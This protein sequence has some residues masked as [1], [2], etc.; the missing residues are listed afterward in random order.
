MPIKYYTRRNPFPFYL[1]CPCFPL[2]VSESFS[3]LLAIDCMKPIKLVK[4]MGIVLR[5]RT[6]VA[7]I[8]S[9]LCPIYCKL[10][11]LGES[12]MSFTI[13]GDVPAGHLPV[14]VGRKTTQ[15]KRFV[16]SVTDLHHP[17][18]Q[19]LLE[20]A[21]QEYG[22]DSPIRQLVIPCDE[23]HFQYI[24]SVLRNKKPYLPTKEYPG[25]VGFS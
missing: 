23:F 18:F 24:M 6:E 12:W 5:W 9:L 7:K 1:S 3:M 22:F 10:F 11:S 13:P 21:A 16:V 25:F 15:Y 19:E 8:T 14:Y 20:K 4:V 2:T 17:L